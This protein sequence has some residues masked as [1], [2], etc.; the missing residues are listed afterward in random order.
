MGSI[1]IDALVPRIN[2]MISFVAYTGDLRVGLRFRASTIGVVPLGDCN[3]A[4]RMQ[5]L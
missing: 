4:H 1:S 3:V 2:S 5:I